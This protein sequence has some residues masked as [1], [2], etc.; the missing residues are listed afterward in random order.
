[1]T[2]TSIFDDKTWQIHLEALLSLQSIS[3]PADKASDYMSNLNGPPDRTQLN[4]VL[5][6]TVVRLH[7]IAVDMEVFLE[8]RR[9]PRKLDVQRC[10]ASM[11]RVRRNLTLMSH[12]VGS[13]QGGTGPSSIV[14]SLT[15]NGTHSCLDLIAT[16]MLVRTGSFLASSST[17]AYL[18]AHQDLRQSLLA[19]TNFICS[20]GN[21]MI[22]ELRRVSAGHR[23]SPSRAL[24]TIWELCSVSISPTTSADQRFE[25]FDAM[26]AIGQLARIPQALGMVSGQTDVFP[27]CRF[28]FRRLR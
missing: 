3:A 21:D 2:V 8:A 18:D 12:V 1:M 17:M 9:R 26:Q 5:H 23:H 6:A 4:R 15:R 25:V 7:R 13:K 10:H 16:L 11:I 28:C 14:L 27:P 20:S 24:H 19:L 22:N